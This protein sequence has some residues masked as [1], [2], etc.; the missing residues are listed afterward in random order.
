MNVL[1]KK[2]AKLPHSPGVYLFKNKSG[3]VIYV[4]KSG[5]LKNRVKSY[6]SPN[7]KF[8][9]PAPTPLKLRGTSKQKMLASIADIEII[10]TESEIEALIKESELIKKLK[11]KFN[12]LM[13]DSKNY[14]FV[15][16]THEDFPK[17]ILTHQPIRNLK[18][19]IRNYVGPFTDGTAVRKTLQVLRDIFPYCTCRQKHSVKCL[20]GHMGRCL[21][22]CCLKKST[23]LQPE[24]DRF[25]VVVNQYRNNI[26]AIKAIL[27]GRNQILLKELKKE[28]KQAV[29]SQNFEL[30]QELKKKIISLDEVFKH[31][32]VL[33]DQPE[34]SPAIFKDD[35]PNLKLL[36]FRSDPQRIET[37]DVSNL[38]GQEA[39]GSMVVFELQKNGLYQANKNEYRQFKI[40]TVSGINDPAMMAEI[41]KRRLNN[42]WPLPQLIIVDGGRT[43]LNAALK[44]LGSKKIRIIGL[45]KKLE[46][47]YLP[48]RPEPILAQKFGQSLKH[49]FQ[50]IRD[51]AHRFALNYHR[52]IRGK[53]Q[54]RG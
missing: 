26:K 44:S 21:T 41:V 37:Y 12:V 50:A 3:G 23:Q 29:K 52:K 39:V 17:I 9:N 20:N 14:L 27:S 42:N 18:L 33:T 30:A 11:P 15:G 54:I 38:H 40:K 24:S 35:K 19:E 2:L 8:F 5:N 10:K 22:Y 51:E 49:L 43:Q 16:F 53:S 47:I 1:A 6:F 48:E 28:I 4:G 31:A 36:G 13:R 45:A 32:R 7:I 25:L 34:L 46:E